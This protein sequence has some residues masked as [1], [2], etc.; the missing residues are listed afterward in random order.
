MRNIRRAPA[1]PAS[2]PAPSCPSHAEVKASITPSGPVDGLD[3]ICRDCRGG[4]GGKQCGRSHKGVVW[5]EWNPSFSPESNPREHLHT[6]A[7]ENTAAR[8]TAQERKKFPQS[9][10]DMPPQV[11]PAGRRDPA[12]S[13]F[14]LPISRRLVREGNSGGYSCS[15]SWPLLYP[16][17]PASPRKGKTELRPDLPMLTNI[18]YHGCT[19]VV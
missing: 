14:S 6:A 10:H 11:S 4:R 9:P 16:G 2:Q 1:Q 3:P 8:S 18:D 17:R 13:T 19:A 7:A 15:G 5:K 12:T